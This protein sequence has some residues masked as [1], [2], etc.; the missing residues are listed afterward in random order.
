MNRAEHIAR[1]LLEIDFGDDVE[2]RAGSP[3]DPLRQ[4]NIP[5]DTGKLD[6]SGHRGGGE[7]PP[8][9]GAVED[10]RRDLDVRQEVHSILHSDEIND[11]QKRTVLRDTFIKELRRR[12]PDMDQSSVE[13]AAGELV[14]DAMSMIA[15]KSRFNI[16]F[17]ESLD[18]VKRVI[19]RPRT[20]YDSVCPHCNETIH[21]KGT[22]AESLDAPLRHSTCGGAIEFEPVDPE[23]V[24]PWLRR[25][26]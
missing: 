6:Y 8:V 12:L 19:K 4:V 16:R 3:R 10:I 9:T 18:E 11:A 25:Y 5:I 20:E 1:Q 14:N 2:P 17:G 15:P 24:D 13:A 7:T 23:T 22:Y 26:L 21:E